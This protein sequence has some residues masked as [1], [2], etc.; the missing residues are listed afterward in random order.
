LVLMMLGLGIGAGARDEPLGIIQDPPLVYPSLAR[1]NEFPDGHVTAVIQVDKE[2]RL[3][4][5]IVT[6]F[7]L[8]EFARA[9]LN[10]LE[11]WTYEPAR[12][13]GEP[14]GVRQKIEFQFQPQ[15]VVLTLYP[16]TVAERRWETILPRGVTRVLKPPRE[17]DAPLRPVETVSPL[18][19]KSSETQR[20]VVDFFVD[21]EGRPRMPVVVRADSDVAGLSAVEALQR[22]RFAPPTSGGE[23]VLTRATQ[24]FVFSPT[25]A[26]RP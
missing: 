11:T 19:V 6:E 7:T 8:R 2:G 13:D 22:W 15:R 10:A 21:E 17:L 14:I 4:D 5:V 1:L 23:P 24:S 26:A 3:L 20:A 25:V 9:V 18:R 12:L 16:T